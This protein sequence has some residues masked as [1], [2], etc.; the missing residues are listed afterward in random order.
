MRTDTNTPLTRL[1]SEMVPGIG[2]IVTATSDDLLVDE[3]VDRI[4]IEP[5]TPTDLLRGIPEIR[6]KREASRG[7]VPVTS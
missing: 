3:K 4:L 6:L 2:I 7:S 1:A 5:F